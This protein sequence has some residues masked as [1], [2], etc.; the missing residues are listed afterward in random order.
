MRLPLAALQLRDAL[1]MLIPRDEGQVMF[2]SQRGDPEIVIGNRSA[3]ALELDKQT[4]VVL[5]CLA[6]REQDI[7]GLLGE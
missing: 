6:P 5:R 1:K 7:H 4:R 3:R 2:Q